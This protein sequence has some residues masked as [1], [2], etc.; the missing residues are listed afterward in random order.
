MLNSGIHAE[1][2][3]ELL[4]PAKALFEEIQ[5]IALF[6]L[7]CVLVLNL[8]LFLAIQIALLILIIADLIT[9]LHRGD[10]DFSHKLQTSSR[11][12]KMKSRAH[13]SSYPAPKF[14]CKITIKKQVKRIFRKRVTNIAH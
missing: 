7:V 3:K 14:V 11:G 5:T 2:H 8:A 4:F 13:R 9:S 10:H 12:L 6:Q 1:E